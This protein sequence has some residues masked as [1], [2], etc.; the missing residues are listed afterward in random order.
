ML[1]D[2]IIAIAMNVSEIAHAVLLCFGENGR[3]QPTFLSPWGQRS[4]L[5]TPESLELRLIAPGGHAV[6][7]VLAR[8]KRALAHDLTMQPTAQVARHPIHPML[9]SGPIVC[10]IGALLTDITYAVRTS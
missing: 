1:A 3:A 9:V 10:F 6:G 7:A 2:G 8:M 5:S 4:N